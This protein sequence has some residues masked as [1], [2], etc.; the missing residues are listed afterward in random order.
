ME[1][2]YAAERL[3]IDDWSDAVYTVTGGTRVE[4]TVWLHN[5]NARCMAVQEGA[6]GHKWMPAVTVSA[7]FKWNDGVSDI[8]R[9]LGGLCRTLG[10][11]S[12]SGVEFTAVASK[13]ITNLLK[14][15]II[16]SAGL[17]NGDAIHTGLCGFG[18]S[19]RTTF[20][21]SVIVFLT[22]RLAFA[23]EYRQKPDLMDEFSAGGEDL[24]T[25]EEDWWDLALAYVVNDHMTVS[26]G[27]ANFGNVLNNEENAVIAIQA[28]YEF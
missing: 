21:G 6:W 15:P 18:D 23:A 3:G 5:V 22:D 24:V 2:G 28:K 11:D 25:S 8:N 9:Q 26:G 19:R 16:I 4:E 7:H 12:T 10:V 27:Y 14:R 13:T 20:E 17:R 1:L